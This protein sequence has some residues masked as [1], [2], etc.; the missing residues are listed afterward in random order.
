MKKIL[1]KESKMSYSVS[2]NERDNLEEN[3]VENTINYINKCSEIEELNVMITKEI[4]KILEE[5]EIAP[6]EKQ[7]EFIQRLKEINA[8]SQE[9]FIPLEDHCR[10]HPE[11][12]E[13]LDDTI[14]RKLEFFDKYSFNFIQALNEY[15][16]QYEEEKQFKDQILEFLFDRDIPT[17]FNIDLNEYQNK[18]IRNNLE[19]HFTASAWVMTDD[20]EKALLTLHK[21]L[22]KCLQLG[23]HCDGDVNILRCAVKEIMEESGVT[24]LAFVNKIFDIDVHTIPELKEKNNQVLIPE[25]KHYDIR[26]LFVLPSDCIP[27]VNQDESDGLRWITKNHDCDQV[28]TDNSGK[29]FKVS[30]GV[31]RMIEKWKNFDIESEYFITLDID[32]EY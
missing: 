29:E 30:Y 20:G 2:N 3:K 1:D 9:D 5:P 32:E 22:G 12:Y 24:T 10:Y 4:N 21:K 17:D 7:E 13:T 14:N 18:F 28:L 16:P 19:G 11:D 8:N 6:V 26:F 27:I 31:K 25:H 23:G 15:E